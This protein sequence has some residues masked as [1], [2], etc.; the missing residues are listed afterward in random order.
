MSPETQGTC[1]SP[2]P[3][4]WIICMSGLDA[5]REHQVRH[6]GEILNC[7]LPLSLLNCWLVFMLPA[8]TRA[9]SVQ[10]R[11]FMAVLPKSKHWL[12]SHRGRLSPRWGGHLLDETN[13]CQSLTHTIII[14]IILMKQHAYKVSRC[15]NATVYFVHSWPQSTA[16]GANAHAWPR[17]ENE[18]S[19]SSRASISIHAFHT[20]VN[21]SGDLTTGGGSI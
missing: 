1:S 8:V 13:N 19:M 11:Q 12:T 9:E 2:G 14:I 21:R 6:S 10:N 18:T 5:D 4:G 16:P 7:R 15:E 17:L 3:Q 20:R